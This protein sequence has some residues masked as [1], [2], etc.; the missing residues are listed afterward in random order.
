MLLF[1][2]NTGWRQFGYRF[3][4]DYAPL[5]FVLLAIG[6]TALRVAL[7]RPGGLGRAHQSVR[8]LRRSTAA[9]LDATATTS[10]TAPR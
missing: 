9:T 1:Y 3:S 8:R 10:G 6:D 7:P 4:N 5:L 2:Q